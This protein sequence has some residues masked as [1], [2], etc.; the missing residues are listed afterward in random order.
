M[1]AFLF[2]DLEHSTRLWAEHGEVMAEALACHDRC[3]GDAVDR[4]GGSVFKRTGDGAC[5]VFDSAGPAVRAAI[6][7]QRALA[8]Q[9]WGATGALRARM[10]VHA[11]PAYERDGDYF[12]P[13]LNRTARVMQAGHGGQIVMSS[14]AAQLTGRDLVLL[15]LGAH[16][17]RDLAEPEHLYQVVADG[18]ERSFAPLRSL[19]SHRHSLPVQ[20]SS[21]V[22]RLREIEA[23]RRLVSQHKLVTLTGVGGTGK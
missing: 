13:T 22:G 2:T 1:L 11:G 9:P 12:G 14:A 21:F 18:L 20:R 6:V 5:A 19:N 23:V 16:R 15:D 7:G 8:A 4:E 10:G 3:I 17:L